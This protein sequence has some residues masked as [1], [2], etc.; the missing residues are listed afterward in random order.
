MIDINL[1]RDLNAFKKM[2][3]YIFNVVT[4]AVEICQDP[5]VKHMLIQ[6]QQHTESIFLGENYYSKKMSVEEETIVYLLTLLIEEENK[7]PV[8]Q[9]DKDFIAECEDWACDLQEGRTKDLLLEL[10]KEMKNKEK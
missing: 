1:I 3:N 7:K 8:S 2:Y 9:Q 5:K 10:E 6:A 4:D